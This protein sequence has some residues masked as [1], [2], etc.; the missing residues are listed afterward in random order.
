MGH[1]IHFAHSVERCRQLQMCNTIIVPYQHI[2]FC[3]R[4]PTILLPK[5]NPSICR[6]MPSHIHAK[7]KA[8]NQSVRVFFFSPESTEA[9]LQA[10][11]K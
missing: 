8:D 9:K 3:K 5:K 11:V 2:T 6:V 1:T 4:K 7:E 10:Q